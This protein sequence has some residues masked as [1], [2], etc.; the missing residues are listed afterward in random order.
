MDANGLK[1][2]ESKRRSVSNL[3]NNTVII[4]NESNASDRLLNSVADN[5]GNILN[6]ANDIVEIK[7]MSVQSEAIIAKMKEE[8]AILLAEA[9]AYAKRKNADTTSIVE[10]MKVIQAMMKDFYQF[11]NSNMTSEDFSKVITEIVTQMGRID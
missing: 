8:R 6:L 11:N 10:K 9:E 5:F 4:D 1:V 2:V 3:D 7:K